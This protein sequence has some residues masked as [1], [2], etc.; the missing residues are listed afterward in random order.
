MI[1][2]TGT[3]FYNPE[4]CFNGL[5]LVA[6]PNKGVLLFDMNGNEIQHYKMM[7]MPAKM[8]PGGN[9]VGT[10][11]FRNSSIAP[12]DGESLIEVNPRGDIV[13]RYD[14]FRFLE[15]ES[16][17]SARAHSDYQCLPNPVGSYV[18][19]LPRERGNTLILGHDTVYNK[20]VSDKP[21]LDEV[22][23]EVDDQGNLVWKF[24]FTNHFDEIG[25]TE[26]QKNV[27]YRNPNVIAGTGLGDYLHISSFAVLGENKWYDQ[28]DRR[29]HPENIIV[30]S[31]QSNFIAIIDKKKRKIVWQ[32]GPKEN[33]VFRTFHGIIGPTHIQMIQKGLKGEGN[34]LLFES[35]AE[36][37]YG[38]ANLNSATGLNSY[39]RAYSRIL[40]FNPITFQV[41]WKV[42]PKDLGY[43]TSLNGYKFYAPYGG[44]L[45]RLPNNNTLVSMGSAGIMYE[46]TE[47]HE[48]VWRWVCPYT[49][50]P[51]GQFAIK[52]YIYGGYRYPYEY[53]DVKTKENDVPHFAPIKVALTEVPGAELSDD[54]D[55]MTMAMETDEEIQSAR[56]LMSME[57]SKIRFIS[58]ENFTKRLGEKPE[59][60]VIYGGNHCVHCKS[61][62]ELTTE[63]LTEEFTDINGFYMALDE[64]QSVRDKLD[65]TTIP[66]TIFYKDGVEVHRFTGEI[67]YDDYAIKIEKFLL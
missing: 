28:G 54:I 25:Y 5:N 51:E 52:N 67:S 2:Q 18:P 31:R 9:I 37:G 39:R 66:L 43:T 58:S 15:S 44:S 7:G 22:I 40:E 19:G 17:Y 48:V 1:F 60:I 36:S 8:L 63:L 53:Y 27:M 56:D 13:W 23:Y 29:F 62:R 32:I 10:G 26:I 42:T 41:Q 11:R 38:V 57:T 21:L 4:K 12:Q 6:T 16:T 55:F 3:T 34:I 61:V 30:A 46:I 64:N 33:E 20:A 24:S 59:T 65:I 50:N 45:Q 35:G 49:V 14:K 47:D